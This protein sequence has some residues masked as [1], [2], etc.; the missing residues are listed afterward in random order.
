MKV[1]YNDA[2]K[3]FELKNK[4]W[5]LKEIAKKYSVHFTTIIYH[6]KKLNKPYLIYRRGR[7]KTLSTNFKPK[8]KVKKM[9]VDYLKNNKA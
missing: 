1:K 4:G 7:Q 5:T 9:Y 3:F 2:N 6:L 8:L